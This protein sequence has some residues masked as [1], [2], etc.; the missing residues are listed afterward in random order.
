MHVLKHAIIPEA[1]KLLQKVL[2]G[3]REGPQFAHK[4]LAMFRTALVSALARGLRCQ[5]ESYS[6]AINGKANTEPLSKATL[7]SCSPACTWHSQALAAALRGQGSSKAQPGMLAQGTPSWGRLPAK[8][9]AEPS[10]ER[11][12]PAP[13]MG[14]CGTQHARGA[15]S[16]WQGE[17]LLR[18]SSSMTMSLNHKLAWKRRLPALAAAWCGGANSFEHCCRRSAAHST[19]SPEL[20]VGPHCRDWRLS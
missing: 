19:S 5:S 6:P 2:A 10:W 4:Q 8:Q 15:G 12:A 9:G 14:I 18:A 16:G 7:E 1:D 20:S 3:E 17:N 11:Q 13:G